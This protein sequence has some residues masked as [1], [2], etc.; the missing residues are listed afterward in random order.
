MKK[1]LLIIVFFMVLLGCSKKHTSDLVPPADYTKWLSSAYRVDNREELLE[2]IEKIETKYEKANKIQSY[3]IN[4]AQLYFRAGEIE[5]TLKVLE[6]EPTIIRFF[7]L[8]TLKKRI[9]REEDGA[10]DLERFYLELT[11]D[12]SNGSEDI[13]KTVIYMTEKLLGHNVSEFNESNAQTL[14]ISAMSQDDL[15]KSIWPVVFQ[16]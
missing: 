8:G 11:G 4:L 5:K 2:I 9:G 12:S 14:I 1:R 15:V 16:K 10:A 6:L 7:Y 3:H 13:D